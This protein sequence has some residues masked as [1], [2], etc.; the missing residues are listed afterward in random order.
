MFVLE[1]LIGNFGMLD[2]GGGGIRGDGIYIN[3]I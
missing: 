3:H 2:R 1:C